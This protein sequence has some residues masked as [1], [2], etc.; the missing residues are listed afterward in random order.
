MN[1]IRLLILRFLTPVSR[2]LGEIYMAPKSRGIGYKE[3]GKLMSALKEGDVLLT[4]SKG[5][6]TNWLIPGEYKHAAI[7]VGDG[8]IVEAVG[9]GVRDV[10]LEDFCASKDK[11]MV[12]R[13]LFSSPLTAAVRAERLVGRPY[14]Y[15]FE[16]S[17]KAFYCAEI[18]TYAFSSPVFSNRQVMGVE[19]TLPDDFRMAEKKFQR[20]LELPLS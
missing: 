14:D 19:T 17:E 9:S 13:A 8:I 4:F 6:F 10:H 11:I 3:I 18:I 1:Y 16:P 15:Q 12:L 20:I 2:F 5:E 7:Y